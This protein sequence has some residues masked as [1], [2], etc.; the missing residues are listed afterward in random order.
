MKAAATHYHVPT[1]AKKSPAERAH[2]REKR[3]WQ[4]QARESMPHRSIHVSVTKGSPAE[5]I[6][7]LTRRLAAGK[8]KAWRAQD[9]RYGLTDEKLW[10]KAWIAVSSEDATIAFRLQRPE[11]VDLLETSVRGI[12]LGR[13]LEL[14]L[15]QFGES[16]GTVTV[17]RSG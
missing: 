12:Y 16:L 6:D 8:V 15:N 10:G 13:F 14:L 2:Y 4:R 3:V 9:G 5:L 11:G 17:S 7:A 1:C